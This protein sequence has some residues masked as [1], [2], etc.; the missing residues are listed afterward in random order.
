LEAVGSVGG[1]R[2]WLCFLDNLWTHAGKPDR[3]F[4]RKAGEAYRVNGRHRRRS[5]ERIGQAFKRS[6]AGIFYVLASQSTF[7]DIDKQIGCWRNGVKEK[8][9]VRK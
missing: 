6:E 7:V 4:F 8:F 5:P 2:V 3:Q 9:E 1:R